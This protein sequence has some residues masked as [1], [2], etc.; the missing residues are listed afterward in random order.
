M[1]ANVSASPSMSS[2]ETTVKLIVQ[3]SVWREAEPDKVLGSRNIEIVKSMTGTGGV[4]DSIVDL[5][6][7]PL[8]KRLACPQDPEFSQSPWEACEYSFDVMLEPIS[9]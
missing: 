4:D 3:F 7:A 6:T 5:A 9:Y 8:V 2:G 1:D